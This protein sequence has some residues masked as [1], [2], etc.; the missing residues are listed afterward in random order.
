MKDDFS[1]SL[2]INSY[3]FSENSGYELNQEIANHWPIVYILKNDNKKEAY[4]GETLNGISRF[5]DHLSNAERRSL[6]ELLIISCDKFNKSATL[7]IESLLIQYMDGDK[8]Y[9][10]QNGNAGISSQNN[11]YQK[12]R[13]KLLFNELWSKLLEK[14]YAKNE[15]NRIDNNDYFKYSPY[16]SLSEDQRRS[17]IQILHS[18]VNKESKIFV[19]GGAGTGKTVLAIYLMKLLTTS[20]QDYHLDDSDQVYSKDIE[21][22]ERFKDRYPEFK[23][24]LV[25]PMTSLRSTL[26][27]VFSSIKGLKA[28][29]VIGPS[30]V[31]KQKYDLLLIDES[32]RLRKRKNLTNYGSFDAVNTKLGFNHGSTELD[33]VL[34]QSTNQLFFYDEYQSIRPSDIS[35]ERF[36]EEKLSAEKISLTSQHRINGG[37]D[38][39]EF[40]DNL[41]QCKSQKSFNDSSYELIL[42]DDINSMHEKLKEKEQKFGLCR[43]LAGYSWEWKSKKDSFAKDIQ[44]DGESYIWNKTNNNWINSPNAINEIGCIHTSQGYDLNYAGIIFG[45]EILY[46]SKT[47]SMHI[48]DTKYFDKNGK[49]GIDNPEKLK[50]YIINIYKTM[51]LRGI[52][53]TYLY[54]CNREL[55]EYFK[56]FID[57]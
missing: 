34:K 13:Y 12:E 39:T 24:A 8:K 52:K 7:H 32:H 3:P 15:I 37:V 51:L 28:N 46:D 57:T 25:I 36:S 43:M 2:K 11:Y 14:D 31:A 6:K 53:G 29:M 17:I 41:L 18:L 22:V 42:F 56:Q 45:N 48:D 26:K 44:I 40:V 50:A 54:V 35:A 5:R 47:N 49:R 23:V 33:W 9:S 55:R 27:K 30:E 20:I 4:I 19:E 16:K 1:S 10:L 38:Y 21:L